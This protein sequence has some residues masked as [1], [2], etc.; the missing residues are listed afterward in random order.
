[1]ESKF[2]ENTNFKDEI[3]SKIGV[4]MRRETEARILIPFLQDLYNEFGKEKILCVLE[5]TIKE[6]ANRSTIIETGYVDILLFSEK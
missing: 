5:K 2:D 4:L 6:I 1:M 3:T